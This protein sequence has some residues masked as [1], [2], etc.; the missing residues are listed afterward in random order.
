MKKHYP[1]CSYK[2]HS[3]TPHQFLSSVKCLQSP[4]QTPQFFSRD[5]VFLTTKPFL[6][7]AK[8]NLTNCWPKGNQPNPLRQVQ[9][10]QEAWLGM[11]L[12]IWVGWRMGWA[13]PNDILSTNTICPRLIAHY[14]SQAS[15]LNNQSNS[16]LP[17][18]QV[19]NGCKI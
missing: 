14:L 19:C 13:L 16:S 3:Y 18:M 4:L 11:C 2:H 17:G 7:V 10:L 12:Y 9:P 15:D 6:L 8:G 5:V 1:L